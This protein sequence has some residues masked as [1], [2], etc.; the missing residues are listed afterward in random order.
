MRSHIQ[1][2]SGHG[3]KTGATDSL[4][5]PMKLQD[6]LEWVDIGV[7]M[8]AASPKRFA[9]IRETL[10]EAL[11]SMETIASFDHQLFTNRGRPTKRYQA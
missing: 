1:S 2:G 10:R 5:R 7:R 3:R 9:E 11:D 6:I 8:A 4:V